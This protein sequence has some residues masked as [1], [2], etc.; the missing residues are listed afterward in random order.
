MEAQAIAEEKARE[1]AVANGLVA[2]KTRQYAEVQ[3]LATESEQQAAALEDKAKMQLLETKQERYAHLL[4]LISTSFAAGNSNTDMQSLLQ[5]SIE[6]QQLSH[7]HSAL[8]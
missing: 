4:P 7:C 6:M 2:E 1:L 5:S 8:A 3:R